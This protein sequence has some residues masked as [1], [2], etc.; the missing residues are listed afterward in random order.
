MAKIDEY[1][2]YTG[3]EYYH[4]R[5]K[6]KFADKQTEA[7]LDALEQRVDGIVTQGGEPNTIDPVSVTGTNVAPDANKNVDI[8]VPTQTSDLTNDGDGNSPFATEAYVGTNGGKIDSISVNGTAQTIDNNKNV[9]ITVPTAVSDLTN[10]SGFQT[11]QEVSDAIDAKVVGAYKYKGSVA[12][13][14]DLPSSGNTAGDVYNVEADGTNYAWTGS[15]WDALGGSFDASNLWAKDELVAITT[16][17]ID[18][19]VDGE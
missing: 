1:L 8:D 9:D 15:A 19:I 17:E 13:V 3:L 10:D 16:A 6:N 7:D 2:D 5:I 11:A 4:S 12:T 18:T 14:A